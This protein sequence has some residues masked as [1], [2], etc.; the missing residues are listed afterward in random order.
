MTCTKTSCDCTCKGCTY[1][2]RHRAERPATKQHC[3]RHEH[4]CHWGGCTT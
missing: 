2:R 4:G 1:T 3:H